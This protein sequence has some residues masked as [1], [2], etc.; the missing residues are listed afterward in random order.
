[1]LADIEDA[2]LF[3]H[4]QWTENSSKKI[5]R[6]DDEESHKFSVKPIGLH[7]KVKDEFKHMRANAEPLFNWQKV[8]TLYRGWNQ[9][10]LETTGIDVPSDTTSVEQGFHVIKC[11][12][13]QGYHVSFTEEVALAKVR[14]SNAKF[15]FGKITG[16]HGKLSGESWKRAVVQHSMFVNW[17]EDFCSVRDSN[18]TV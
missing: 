4:R 3:L 17:A 12:L 15:N 16:D 9:A 14:V 2:E 18:T 8:V 10:A 11:D 13:T 5:E 7:P 1:M 6:S